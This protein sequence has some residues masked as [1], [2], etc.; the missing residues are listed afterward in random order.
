MGAD[1]EVCNRTL[2]LKG[3]VVV[4]SERLTVVAMGILLG[5]DEK[6]VLFWTLTMEIRQQ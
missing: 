1:W 3:F 2:R 6:S 5:D 4:R